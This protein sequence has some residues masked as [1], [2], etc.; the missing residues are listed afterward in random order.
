MRLFY[1]L[2][3]ASSGI[4]FMTFIKRRGLM[5]VLSSPSGAGKT[6]IVKEILKRDLEV[7]VSVSTTTRSAR[8]GEIH[9]KDYFF[10]SQDQFLSM[11]SQDAFLENAEVFGNFYG[12]PKDFVNEQLQSGHDVIFDI[13]WQGT[14]QIAQRARHDLVTVFI[15]PPSGEELEKRLRNRATDSEDV[16]KKRMNA[17]SSEISHWAE[18]DYV[19]I[20]HDLEDSVEKVHS[21]LKTERLKR[22]RQDGLTDFV[23]NIRTLM[24][25]NL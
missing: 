18:Y 4:V 20:N 25:S 3:V 24:K 2:F 22:T 12:T 23:N 9:G 13:D 19:I 7:S 6:T 14:Q 21:I 16:L 15:L 5:L 17:A 10:V 8:P 11:K 1:G